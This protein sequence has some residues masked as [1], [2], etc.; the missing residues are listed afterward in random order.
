MSDAP[1]TTAPHPDRDSEATFVIYD[2]CIDEGQSA[3]LAGLPLSDNG[4]LPSD[5]EWTWWREGYQA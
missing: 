2:R 1:K 4:Y 5:K 3:Y